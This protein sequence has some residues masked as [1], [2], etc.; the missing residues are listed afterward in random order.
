M[1]VA[2][3]SL[4]YKLA[5]NEV[6]FAVDVEYDLTAILAPCPPGVDFNQTSLYAPD[7]ATVGAVPVPGCIYV[8][9][10][11]ADF[12]DG[13]PTTSQVPEIFCHNLAGDADATKT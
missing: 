3:S 7:A 4:E 5:D 9:A 8:L 10:L 2:A 11:V 13:E 1:A 6:H 12:Q